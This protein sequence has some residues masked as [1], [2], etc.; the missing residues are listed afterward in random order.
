[1]SNGN[2]LTNDKRGKVME[3]LKIVKYGQIGVVFFGLSM[4]LL[5]IIDHPIFALTSMF[6]CLF[7]IYMLA[8][9]T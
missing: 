6:C 2:A 5:I 3:R 4:F 7:C 9:R 8:T 1:M